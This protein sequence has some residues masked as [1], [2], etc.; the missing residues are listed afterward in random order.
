MYEVKFPHI[1]QN[2][3]FESIGVERKNP[4]DG[5]VIFGMGV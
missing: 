1:M 2:T 4:Y 5:G 3:K